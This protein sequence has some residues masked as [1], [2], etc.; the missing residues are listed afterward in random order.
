MPESHLLYS[1]RFSDLAPASITARELIQVLSAFNSMSAKATFH[2]F[3]SVL[4][5]HQFGRQ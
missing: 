4:L 3:Q 5:V 1:I 2:N